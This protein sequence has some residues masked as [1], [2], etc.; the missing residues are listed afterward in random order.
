MTI[1]QSVLATLLWMSPFKAVAPNVTMPETP[2]KSTSST[3]GEALFKMY[4][5]TCHGKGAKGD[6]PLADSLSFRPPDLTLIAKRQGG[7]FDGDWVYRIIDGRNPIKGHGGPDM[8][9]W[10]DAFKNSAEGY[11]EKA[12]T[13]RIQAIVEHLKSLQTK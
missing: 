5:A 10:G 13:T 1:V 2:G 4:C 3:S 6:G 11:S 12:V 7:K 8:P 9:V